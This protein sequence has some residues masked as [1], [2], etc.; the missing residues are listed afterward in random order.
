MSGKPYSAP[1][2]RP[3]RVKRC[4]CP[5]CARSDCGIHVG[6]R[7]DSLAWRLNG[8]REEL[9]RAARDE[10]ADLTRPRRVPVS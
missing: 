2:L 7:L 3:L 9:Q 6:I 1:N 10:A 4:R 5:W 8:L